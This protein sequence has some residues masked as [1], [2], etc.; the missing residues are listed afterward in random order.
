MYGFVIV[1]KLNGIRFADDG[2][3]IV[4]IL[5]VSGVAGFA[6]T[7]IDIPW[8]QVYLL[9]AHMFCSTAMNVT[10]AITVD[11]YPTASR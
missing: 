1:I 9:I 4:F 10:N 7:L 3:F 6:C 5:A 8:L 11:I 2:K